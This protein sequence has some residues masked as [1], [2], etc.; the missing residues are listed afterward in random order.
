MAYPETK[1]AYSQLF[2]IVKKRIIFAG[3]AVAIL[4]LNTQALSQSS[5]PKAVIH[6]TVTGVKYKQGGNLIFTLYNSKETWFVVKKIYATKV[7]KVSAE[8]ASVDFENIPYADTYAL[9]AFHDANINNKLDFSWFPFPHPTEG[10][11][12][13]NNAVR[14]GEPLYEK[15]RF[16]VNSDNVVLQIKMHY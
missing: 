16:T 13:S 6:V 8:T 9:F 12:V 1:P 7:V 14:M 4:S 3:I 10:V 5:I 11:A 2:L 15:A